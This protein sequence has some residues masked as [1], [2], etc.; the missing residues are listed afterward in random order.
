MKNFSIP[1]SRRDFFK[2]AGLTTA[3]VMLS[4]S[5]EEK[6]VSAAENHLNFDD[7]K[8]PTLM[9]ADICVCG[10]GPSG[11]AAAITAAKNGAKVVLI[12]R[13]ISLGGLQTLGCVYPCMPT[14][15]YDSDTPYIDEIK[16]E[17]FIRL[18]FYRKFMMKCA[19]KTALK[20]YI[21]FR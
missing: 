1:M 14:F 18:K 4:N 7:K 20:F 21:I 11:T 9:T 12:E 16:A 19:K 6:K 15:C 10:G 2:L 8:I 3:G 17:V 5:G 13:G